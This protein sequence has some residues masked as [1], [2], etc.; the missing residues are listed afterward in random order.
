MAQAQTLEKTPGSRLELLKRERNSLEKAKLNFSNQYD[1]LSQYYYQT[2]NTQSLSNAAPTQGDFRNDGAINDNIGY[3]SAKAMAS[4][5]MGMV[6]KD[7]SGTFRLVRSKAVPDSERNNE[8]F[9]RINNNLSMFFERPK[10]RF[11]SSLFKVILENVIYGTSGLTV[12]SGGYQNP[13]KFHQKSILMFYL[14]YDKDGEIDTIFIDYHMSAQ[15]LYDEYGDRAGS[16]VAEA[17]RANDYQRRF[18]VTEAIKPRKEKKA[19]K[20]KLAMPFSSELFMPHA[21]VFLQTGGYESLPLKVVFYD[22]LEHESYGRGVGMT[23]LPTVMQLQVVKEVLA[24]GGELIAQPAMGMF[25]NGTLAGLT[26]DFSP[27]ALS[28]FNVAGTIPTE[29]PVFPLFQIGD[30]SVIAAWEQELKKEIHEYF[31]LDKLYDLGQQ[32]QRKTLGEVMILDAIRS[33]SLTPIFTQLLA[34]F[35]RV[36]E[37]SVDITFSMGLLGVADPSNTDDPTVVKLMENGYEPFQIPPDVLAVQKGGLDW[38]DV[39]YINPASRIMNNEELQSTLRFLEVIGQAGGI[40]PEFLDII[41]PDK[42]GEKMKELTATDT[43]IVRPLKVRQEIRDSRREMQMEM[44]KL[45]AQ[46]QMATARQMNAQASAAQSGAVR[47]L[48]QT[49]GTPQ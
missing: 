49:E 27:G 17:V 23:A 3:K 12:Q 9:H 39:E 43:V 16:Q 37:R 18:V 47:N 41:D 46:V 30:L 28:V 1:V 45:E 15:E 10:S 13:L 34:F 26:V 32:H 8:Y 6:W 44:A 5:I 21:N 29:Q 11:V 7:E 4:A 22:K 25:D 36:L 42:T 31:L 40:N 38:Y 19:E 14:G 24:I 35:T 33:D 2:S 48:S 20:G